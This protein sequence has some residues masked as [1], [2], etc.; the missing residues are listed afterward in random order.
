MKFTKL[1][2]ASALATV[3]VAPVMAGTLDGTATVSL[4]KAVS[5]T[6]TIDVA[7]TVDVFGTISVESEAGAVLDNEQ[8]STVVVTPGVDT[9]G[10]GAPNTAFIDGGSGD[11]ATGNVGINVAAGEGN[12]QA[13]D[14]A[15]AAI[16]GV[17]VFADAEIFSSQVNTSN[18]TTAPGST[19]TAYIDGS[20]TGTTGNIG[21][22]VVAGDGN[23]QANK[24]A[25][26]VNYSGT[27]AK[28]NGTAIQTLNGIYG[29]GAGQTNLAY[30]T[31]ALSGGTGNLGANVAAGA[32][33]VQF[34]GLSVA[35]A[36]GTSTASVPGLTAP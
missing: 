19:N 3:F 36:S 20:L 8:T 31:G 10:A 6:N 7:G 21:V 1:T 23:L 35:I 26:S 4:Y 15:L 11:G 5:V 18:V 22:N 14:V 17:S 34:N 28:A 27:I 24:T 29:I 30:L 32:G 16:D 2:L 33:N 25:A 12:G 13:N 9:T